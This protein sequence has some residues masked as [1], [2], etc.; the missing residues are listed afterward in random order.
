[1]LSRV[2]RVE[3]QLGL[4]MVV[5]SAIAWSLAGFFTRLIPL[6]L[7]TL[8]AWRGL[9]GALG[10]TAMAVMQRSGKPRETGRLGLLGWLYAGVSA[11]GMVLFIAA[12][13]YTSVAHVSV[14][15][16]T[17]PFFAAAL[18]WAMLREK[19][20]RSALI[21]SSA[22][23]LG[24]GIM[25]GTG[26]EGSLF[27][28]C[29]AVGM[30]LAMAAMMVIARQFRHVPAMRAAALSALLS[31]LVA[32]PFGHP[33]A[34]SGSDF[35]L[36]ALFGLVNSALG[37]A[38]FTQGARLLSPV[39]TALLGSLDAPLAPLWVW[40]AFGETPR[41]GT[42]LGGLV[43]FLAVVSHIAADARRTTRFNSA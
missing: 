17:V 9:F 25:V 24:V 13:A 15:Y 3:H 4:A 5:G 26:G 2:K 7:W 1:V 36:L 8:L 34:P 21:A 40:L 32:W 6:D 10:I 20:S 39:E 37:L 28:D 38:L 43:V 14:I 16:A 27:G 18:A 30:T 35:V 29:L 23:L 41:P 11:F 19:P 22:A 33:L 31:G 42:I 12:L